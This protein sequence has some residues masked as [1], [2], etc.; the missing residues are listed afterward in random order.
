[1]HVHIVMSVS[2]GKIYF[3]HQV[4]HCLLNTSFPHILK[5]TVHSN[6]WKQ[7]EKEKYC[8][9]EIDDKTHM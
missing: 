2:V 7:E 3:F 1:M 5:H 8:E 6:V 4:F 9:R